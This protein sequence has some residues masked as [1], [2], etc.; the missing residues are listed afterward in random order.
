MPVALDCDRMTCCCWTDAEEMVR[1][2]VDD[3]FGFAYGM[4]VY[5]QSIDLLILPQLFLLPMN[6]RR[7]LTADGH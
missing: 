4:V 2:K 3:A 5:H 1:W 7:P 6:R